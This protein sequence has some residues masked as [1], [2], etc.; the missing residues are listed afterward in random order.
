MCK[1]EYLLF[2][3][4]NV[5]VVRPF[6]MTSKMYSVRVMLLSSSPSLSAMMGPRG[7]KQVLGA[8]IIYS[9]W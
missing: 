9:E 5:F 2:C 1:A 3:Y 4:T 8:E 7:F 6:F